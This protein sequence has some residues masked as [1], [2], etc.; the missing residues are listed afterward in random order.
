MPEVQRKDI[1]H[2]RV[3][4]KIILLPYALRGI[5]IVPVLKG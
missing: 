3:M 5:T 4:M 1:R 2:A